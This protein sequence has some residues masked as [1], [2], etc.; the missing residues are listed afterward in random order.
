[1]EAEFYDKI[2][3]FCPDFYYIGLIEDLLSITIPEESENF[4]GKINKHISDIFYW[5]VKDFYIIT[6]R[7]KTCQLFLIRGQHPW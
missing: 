4:I 2:C 6:K 7:S 1:M 3:T 5:T